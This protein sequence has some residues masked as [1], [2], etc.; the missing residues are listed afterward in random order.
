MQYYTLSYPP[1]DHSGPSASCAVPWVVVCWMSVTLGV[2]CVLLSVGLHADVAALAYRWPGGQ[3]R[4]TF[5]PLRPIPSRPALLSPARFPAPPLRATASGPSVVQDLVELSEKLTRGLQPRPEGFPAGPPGDST[6]ELVQNPLAFFERMRDQF[7]GAIGLVMAGEYVVVVSDPALLRQILVDDPKSFPKQGSAFFPSLTDAAALGTTDGTEWRR[8]RQL[9]APSY[10]AKAVAAY[11]ETMPRRAADWLAAVWGKSATRAHLWDDYFQLITALMVKS[12]AGADVSLADG[13]R[14]M[15]ALD[16]YTSRVGVRSWL[17]NL[18]PDWAPLP[19]NEQASDAR[20]VLDDYF[21][22]VVAARQAATAAAGAEGVPQDY[23]QTLLSAHMVDRGPPL[24]AKDV[25]DELI[26]MLIGQ[27]PVAS[28]LAWAT[29]YLATRPML[30]AAVR[31]EVETVLGGRLP[32]PDDMRRLPALTGLVLE[33]L[34]L[35]PPTALLP[36]YVNATIRFGATAVV[37]Q[38]TT[39]ILAA[40][41][42]H[43]DPRH[44][45]DPLRFA[46]E[47]WAA[48]LKAAG[49]NPIA[50]IPDLGPNGAFMPFGLGARTCIAA[51]LSLTAVLTILA[52]VVQEYTLTPPLAGRT[53]PKPAYGLTLKPDEF[54]VTFTS[55]NW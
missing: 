10:R 2:L 13:R 14:V 36:R 39:V 8:R 42:L 26:G 15:E 33:V 27:E 7:G 1:A 19:L 51:Q 45:P 31:R 6:L 41:L 32:H 4:S 24:T 34:R 44:W 29:V 37:P 18:L 21:T 20:R 9:A 40:Y 46:P 47:R 55:R 5:N 25:R 53:F 38:G 35:H 49:N 12:M 16:V 22:T 3:A 43:R 11:M 28:T 52:H 30:Q 50:L 23:L 17:A 54:P 48:W